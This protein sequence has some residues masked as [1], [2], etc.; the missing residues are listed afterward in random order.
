MPAELPGETPERCMNRAIEKMI[1]ACPSQY[2]WAYNRYK[3]PAGV[4]AADSGV[5]AANTAA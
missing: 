2:L 5:T 1:R 3:V 4:P